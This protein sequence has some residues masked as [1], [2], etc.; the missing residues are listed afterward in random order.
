VV[1]QHRYLSPAKHLLG[2]AP[3][4]YALQ[5]ALPGGRDGDEVHAGDLHLPQNLGGVVPEADHAFCGEAQTRRDPLQMI[6]A[7][8]LQPLHLLV[9][10]GDD[11]TLLAYDV[12]GDRDHVEES[13]GCAGALGEVDDEGEDR[14]RDLRSIEWNQDSLG[15]G[16][17]HPAHSGIFEFRW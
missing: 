14:L 12:A 1:E 11:A 2:H 5:A 15:H 7:F 9:G 17:L 6:Q 3:H 4:D 10:E 13:Y 16:C 8:G